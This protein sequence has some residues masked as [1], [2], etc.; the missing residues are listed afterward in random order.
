MKPIEW[1]KFQQAMTPE[2][3][4]MIYYATGAVHAPHHA[5]KEF[6]EKYDGKFDDGWLAYREATF[7]RQKALGIIPANAKL[8]PM[9]EDIMEWESLSD[10]ERE[11]YACRWRPLQA[12]R[13]IPTA[14]SA[15]W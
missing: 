11:L 8:A 10:Q 15:D 1:V 13:N 2:K 9:P 4:F 14:K 5:P 12:S 3:P 6:I 7:E